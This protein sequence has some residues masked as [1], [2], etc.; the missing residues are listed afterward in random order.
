MNLRF[1]KMNGLIAAPFTPMDDLGEIDLSVVPDYFALLKG[2]GVNGAF[3]C[4][5]TGEGPSLT[6]DEKKALIA[7]WVKSAKEDPDFKIIVLVGGNNI[8]DCESLA[9][10]C[11]V[12]GVDA[13]AFTAPSY[14]KPATLA[15]LV[16]C[17]ETLASKAAQLP[18]YYYHIPALTGV[19]FLMRELL[20]AASS[21]IPNLAGIKYTHEDF[22]DYLSCIHFDN[23]RYDILWGRDE[24]FLAALASGA[25]GAVGSTFNYAA[26]LYHQIMDAFN[27]G[28]FPLA[29]KLQQQSIDMIQLL[30]KYGGLGTGKAFM[31]SVDLECGQFRLPVNNLSRA[32]ELAFH[33]DLE[34]I[35]F[36]QY[37][38]RRKLSDKI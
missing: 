30:G 10:W 1:E 11:A 21:T 22:M 26:P 3:I 8:K 9:A 32:Q 6:V 33:K 28:N 25:T 31:R 17:C 29:R 36:Y 15:Q 23:G 19:H 16:A 18:F 7:A 20:M 38:S 24:S 13:I 27:E 14:F 2:N 37:C 5:S 34:S 4:G 12:S 35:G